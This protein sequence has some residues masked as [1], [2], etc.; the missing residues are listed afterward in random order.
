MT[1]IYILKL[2]HGKYYVG[3]TD[4]LEQRK[5]QHI[6]G[7]AS[8]WTKKHP[9]ISVEQI[10]PNAS[11]FDEDKYT[12]EYMHKYGIDNVRGGTYVTE[13]LD[14]N[15]YY[16]IQKEIWGAKNLCTQCGRSGHFVKYCK[17]DK[18]VNGNDIYEYADVWGCEYCDKEFETEDSCEKHERYC[19]SK[20]LITSTI[21]K[22]CFNCGESGHY[23]N[24]CPNEE[25]FNCRY[26]NKEFET[27]KGAIFHENVHC[28]NKN[29]NKTSVTKSVTHSITCYRCGRDG[30]KSPDCYART[31]INGDELDSDDSY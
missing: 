16:N 27:Q 18:D 20:K 31:D 13:E 15:Q 22:T 11:D 2:Q 21:S 1:N 3:K 30:H 7:T 25:S 28:K 24:E 12:K 23:A 10:I 5:Q 29:K 4:N 26:C 8:T 19:K 9:P 14:E 6:N 17:Y